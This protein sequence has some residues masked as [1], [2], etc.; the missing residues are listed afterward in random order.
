MSLDQGFDASHPLGELADFI[1]HLDAEL[2]DLLV[3][4]RAEIADLGAELADLLVQVRA[5]DAGGDPQFFG[6]QRSFRV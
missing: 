6:G 3:Q 1:V 5:E 2:A 4:V